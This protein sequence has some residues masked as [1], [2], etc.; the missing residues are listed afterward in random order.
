MN[1][2]ALKERIK[3]KFNTISNFSRVTGADRYLLQKY[4]SSPEK[5]RAELRLMEKSLK[6]FPK[7]GKNTVPFD[8]IQKL[9]D[10]I[11]AEG[12]AYQFCKKNPP[13][14]PQTIFQI[15]QGKRKR[16]TPMMAALFE[17]FNIK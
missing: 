9:T 13:F 5:Y 14:R 6:N 1:A 11:M 7:P 10:A 15:L 17:R 12:G 4:F 3:K 16:V 2:H 8:K